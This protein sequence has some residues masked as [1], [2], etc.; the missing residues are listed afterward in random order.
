M[1]TPV[2]P[3]TPR[4]DSADSDASP[5]T[6]RRKR[7]SQ[8]CGTCR[9]RKLRCDG[10][11]PCAHCAKS[12][13]LATCTYDVVSSSRQKNHAV[14]YSLQLRERIR[15]LEHELSLSESSPSL[16]PSET[17]SAPTISPPPALVAAKKEWSPA[18]DDP[19]GFQPTPLNMHL[20]SLFLEN[21]AEKSCS[22]YSEAELRQTFHFDN[23]TP[24]L[25]YAAYSQAALYS[26]HPHLT[27]FFASG[28]E[29][30]DFYARKVASIFNTELDSPS[31][32]NARALLVVAYREFVMGRF[33]NAWSYTGLVMSMSDRALTSVYE[34][35][36]RSLLVK[37]DEL[38]HFQ[39]AY[40]F[41]FCANVVASAATGQCDSMTSDFTIALVEATRDD[42]F[43]NA[44]PRPPWQWNKIPHC[45]LPD[46][47][48]IPANLPGAAARHSITICAI[49]ARILQY[50]NAPSRVGAGDPVRL[51]QLHKELMAFRDQCPATASDF[52]PGMEL[53][54]STT[55]NLALY[56]CAVLVLHRPA[57]L[58]SYM[59][60]STATCLSA[61]QSLAAAN[62]LVTIAT[63]LQ[64]HPMSSPRMLISYSLLMSASVFMHRSISSPLSPADLGKLRVLAD[65]MA[66]LNV[67]YDLG[68]Q[69]AV[70]LHKFIDAAHLPHPSDVVRLTVMHP[71]IFSKSDA[72]CL[73][74]FTF[75]QLQCSPRS[76]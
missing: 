57:A 26:V 50:V 10:E 40:A 38:R 47:E 1:T 69:F 67:V 17:S 60:G 76:S 35:E 11:C 39:A 22:F 6:P 36:F 51:C 27:K 43:P 19:L 68:D 72:G 42:L 18:L 24:V 66:K 23:L 59:A 29:C 75:S 4:A 21:L 71:R 31:T 30:A 8:A 14:R 33:T 3:P 2:L 12:G 53:S 25:A 46:V 49:L 70:Y 16:P 44:V 64:R 5:H 32:D 74:S 9:R 61:Q 63:F 55:M 28:A 37:K 20:V 56:N 52:V 7:L 58:A 54:Y 73:A 45:V 13:L 48:L 34:S 65:V 41:A 62:R 15:E